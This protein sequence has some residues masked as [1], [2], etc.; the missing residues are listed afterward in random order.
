MKTGVIDVGGGLRGIYGAGVFDRCM[1]EGVSFDCCI[2][3]SAGAANIVSYMAGQSKRNYRFYTE[4]VFRK[5]YM[6]VSNAL[7]TGS[8]IGLD[9]IYGELSNQGGED[10]LDYAAMVS[11]G[12]EAVIVATDAKT[13]EPHYFTLDDMKQND[14]GPIKASSCVP[15]IDK[16]YEIDGVPYFDGGLSDPIPL[17]QAEDRGC[18]RIVVII[19]KPRDFYRET[20]ADARMARL[21]SR[22]WP[23]SAAALARRG[24][25][26]NFG[27]DRAKKLEADGRAL[28]VA[29]DDTRGMKTL[30]KDK[31]AMIAIYNKGY[32]DAASISEFLAR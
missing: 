15:V 4:Y 31:R 3:V 12:K 8:Y 13:A 5:K 30:T 23:R 26:Y 27:L 16:P 29:P 17:G 14:Y 10:P 6:S 7:R 22:R 28:I 24:D 19:T 32:K 11:S 18:E 1:E 20:K 2:G 21:L 25:V 9:Y